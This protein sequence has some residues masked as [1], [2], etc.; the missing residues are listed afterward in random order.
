MHGT[1][2]QYLVYKCIKSWQWYLHTYS[3]IPCIHKRTEIKGRCGINTIKQNIQNIY[4]AKY[5][6]LLRA[7]LW[8]ILTHTKCIYDVNHYPYQV[9]RMLCEPRIR[10]GGIKEVRIPLDCRRILISILSASEMNCLY[11]LLRILWIILLRYQNFP[12]G[13]SSIPITVLDDF[14][15]AYKNDISHIILVVL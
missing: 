11:C 12:Q 3:Y 10:Q 4:G 1:L 14:G 6:K 8:M 13:F 9:N 2:T 15:A 5:Y 7:L